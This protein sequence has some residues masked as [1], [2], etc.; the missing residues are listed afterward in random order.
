MAAETSIGPQQTIEHDSTPPSD[1]WPTYHR[2]MFRSGYDPTFSQFTSATLNWKSTTLDGD[3]YAEPLIVG[4]VVIVAT[5]QN[6]LYELNATTG[7]I[8]WHIN[9]GTPVNGA[10]LP[11]GDINPS[12]ITGTPV[13]DVTGRTIFVV[14]YL[15]APSLHH[16]LFAVDLDT[17]NVR[18]Q[19][20]IDPS[21]ANFR[22]QYQQQRAALALSN[23]YVYVAYGGLDGDCGPYHG[24]L[25]ATK[26]NDG[27][28]LISYQVPTGRAGA[29]WGGGSGP[30][31]DNSSDLLVATGNSDA[32]STFDFG[33]SV[34]N[35]SPATSGSITELDYFAPLNW[36][37]LNSEDLDLG[38][39][40]PVLLNSSLL[41]QIGKEGVGYLLNATNLGEIGG[42]LYSS[43]VCNSGGGAYGGLAYSF[44]YLIVPCDNGLVALKVTLGVNPSFAVAWRGSDYEAGPPIIA[45]NAVWDV[46]VSGGLIYALSL[47]TGETLFQDTIG[48]LPTHFNSL[49]AG[50]GQIFVPANRQVLAYLPYPQ[51]LF[52]T[53]E[54]PQ[55]GLKSDNTYPTLLVKVTN[56]DAV[57]VPGASVAIYV[58]GTAIC[59]N[60]LSSTTGVASC[61]FE[62]TS[63]GTYDW[64][65]TAQKTGYDSAVAPQTIFTFTAGPV[66]YQIPLV[67]GWNL[68]SIPIV[69]ANTA[70]G[71]VL[72]SQI[73]GGN[74][75]VIWSYQGGV[76]KSATLNPIAHTLSGPLT[77]I[78]DGVGYWV[79]MNRADKLFVVGNVFAPLPATPPSYTLSAGWN[80][81]GFKPQPTV[82]NE[83]VGQYLTSISGSYDQNN[84]WIY[85]NTS[86]VWIR[87]TSTTLT[88]GEAMWIYVTSP[89]GATLT[90]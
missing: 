70:I 76:W 29:I 57:P 88:P 59:T 32:T 47:N 37:T 4:T 49:S 22:V 39:T 33:D 58:N 23:G 87:G 16:E 72:G 42:Q 55:N 13:I 61:P 24:W 40:E 43:P 9:F 46:D 50:D 5:E 82:Q 12:G 74:L 44:P 86:G 73:A 6:S 89:S 48:T 62:V 31:V 66:V 11:C 56:P 3:V 28:P 68:I 64:Y 27:G 21:S 7:Q 25:V 8:I 36:A 41:F 45:G 35:L 34:I 60:V 17:G 38:S 65:G 14:A 67:E 53:P 30:V 75:T 52:V 81:V 69:P 10:T 15:Q 83:T 79:F 54:T 90:P 78:Q 1:N 71:T 26:T 20:P 19:L 51:Q 85:D 77:T 63:T 84:V 18:F 2:D 80:L